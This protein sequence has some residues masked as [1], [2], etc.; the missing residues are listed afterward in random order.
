MNKEI[1]TLP[2]LLHLVDSSNKFND[3]K[4]IYA[5]RVGMS[6][7]KA[8]ILENYMNPWWHASISP[9]NPN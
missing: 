6:S 2:G 8:D 9:S 3:C 1:M 7:F 4:T 5:V